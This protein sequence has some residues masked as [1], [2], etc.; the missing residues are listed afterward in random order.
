LSIKE[1]LIINELLDK[2]R[3]DWFYLPLSDN[4]AQRIALR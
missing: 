1:V 4:F 2:I 3:K